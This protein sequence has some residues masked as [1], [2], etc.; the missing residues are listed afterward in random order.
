MIIV[1]AVR[2]KSLKKILKKHRQHA[3]TIMEVVVGVAIMGVLI[4]GA[5][6]AITTL[7][8]TTKVARE[9]TIL[10]SLVSAEL[11]VVRNLPYSAIGTING[12]PNGSL[13]DA[14]NPRAVS[15]ENKNFEVYYEVAYIDD[16]ADGL[17]FPSDTAPNDY[18]QVKLF[19]RS[20]DTNQ[21]TTTLTT[22]APEHLEDLTNG[23]ALEIS[24][25]N[26]V[27]QPVEGAEVHIENTLLEPDIIVDRTTDSSGRWVEIGLPSSVNG[28]HVVV[29]KPGYS[30]DQTYPIT[31][32]NPNPIKPDVTIINGQVTQLSFAIDLLANLTIRTV[33]EFCQPISGVD[34]NVRGDKLI[35]TNPNVYK[36]NQDNTSNGSGQVPLSDIE[37]DTYTPTLLAGE[38]YTIFGTSPIQQIDVLPASTQTFTFVLGA[39]SVNSLRVIVKDASTGAALERATVHI[40]KGGE[41]AQEF[42]GETAGSVWVQDDWTEGAGQENFR[43][44]PPN[45]DEKYFA[46]DGNIDINSVPTGVRLRKQTG[47]YVT[48]GELESSTF[49]TGTAN[50]TFTSLAWEPTSQHAATTLKFQLASSNDPAG[51]WNYIGPDG[52]DETFYTVPGSA[53]HA[54]HNSDQYIRYKVFLST[55]DTKHTPILTTIK[56]NYISGCATP[57]QKMFLNLTAGNNWHVDVSLAGYQTQVIDPLTISGN[58]ALEVLLSP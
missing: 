58:T 39:P 36:F 48:P 45:S 6:A 5:L 47:R 29:T 2:N 54:S 42:D 28:Y 25:I 1:S 20:T 16:P 46:D 56:V 55:T 22:V 50:N 23:G 38:P 30:I 10:S 9:K 27:G 33:D 3:F 26:A 41:S 19:I 21:V 17:S 52:T 15:V 12:N 40:I 7:T 43:P 8:N 4:A 32:E 34:L 31:L 49:D 18:K 53:I 57:G 11:E 35:G 24:V 37:W 51:P 44:Q 13:P 14:V